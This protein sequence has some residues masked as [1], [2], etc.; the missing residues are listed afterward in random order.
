MK[1]KNKILIALVIGLTFL[2]SIFLDKNFFNS[3]KDMIPSE[4]DSTPQD[5]EKEVK[6]ED[7]FEVLFLDVGQAES[8][9]IKSNNEYMLIDAGNNADGKKL[10]QYFQSLGI[11]EFKY[12]VGNSYNAYNISA[13]LGFPSLNVI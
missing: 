4:E 12:V 13:S 5:N 10:V 7:N 6:N 9:L 11:K 8:I 3:L 1:T 2:L